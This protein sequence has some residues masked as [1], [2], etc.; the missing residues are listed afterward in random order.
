M[1]VECLTPY[2]DQKTQFAW[3]CH[4]T[5][6][7]Q[8]GCYALVTYGGNILYVGLAT[9]SI[10]SRMGSHLDTDAKRK[11]SGLGVPF[12]FYYL[13]RAMGEVAPIERGWMNQSILQD[14]EMPPLNKVYS[15]L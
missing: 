13:V 3:S 9:T 11:G 12:W 7:D 15:P 5:V 8:P 10:R 2:P 14:G 6:P 1:R 4:V